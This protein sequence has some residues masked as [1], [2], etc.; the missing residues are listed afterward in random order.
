MNASINK[1]VFGPWVLVTGASSGIG[2]EFA[3]QLAANNFNLALSSRRQ[4]V[5]EEL[6]QKLHTKY[7][8]EYKV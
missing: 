8:I 6:G 4:H 7:G 3:K 2:K 5:L 1:A